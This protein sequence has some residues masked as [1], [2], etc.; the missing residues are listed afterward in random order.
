MIWRLPQGLSLNEPKHS[1]CPYCKNTL[2]AADLVPLFS[3]LALGRKCR[4]CKVPISPRYFG[5]ELLTGLLF[6]GLTLHFLPNA[7]DCVTM[8]LFASVLVPIFFI[9]LDTFTIP[10]SLTLLAFVIPVARDVLG[11]VQH[12]PNHALVSGWL[13]V[14][15]LGAVAGTLIFGFVR[16]AGW[17][18]SPYLTGVRQEAMGLGDVLLGRGMGAMLA[19]LVPL[20][21]NSLRLFPVWVMLSV[22]SGAVLGI[23]LKVYAARTSE[24][25]SETEAQNENETDVVSEIP[26]TFG[27]ELLAIGWCL[28]LGDAWEYLAAVFHIGKQAEPPKREPGAEPEEDNWK[29]AATAIPFGPYMVA[30]FVATVFIGEWLTSAYLHWAFPPALRP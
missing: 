20:G 19:L 27:Q 9:D 29:P 26:S 11:I 30:G 23:L 12:E 28:W 5:V 24:A 3:Y 16:V 7:A 8:L 4:Q 15:L 6:V 22:S 21:T 10:I 14:S 18:A 17:L 1:F 2:T 25:A 13:P